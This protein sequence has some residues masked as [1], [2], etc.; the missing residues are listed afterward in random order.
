MPPS[1]VLACFYH[2]ILPAGLV[3]RNSRRLRMSECGAVNRTMDFS[4]SAAAVPRNMETGLYI[5]SMEKDACGVGFVASIQGVASF[6]VRTHE[7]IIP[8]LNTDVSD[9]G[10]RSFDVGAYG[11]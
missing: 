9:F 6:K 3:L 10:R 7:S 2:R 1:A 11:A 5:P 8:H 4:T